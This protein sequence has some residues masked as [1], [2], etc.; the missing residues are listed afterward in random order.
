MG[1][2]KTAIREASPQKA[3]WL[4]E[5]FGVGP[6]NLM[7]K[8]MDLFIDEFAPIYDVYDLLGA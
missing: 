2:M 4:F 8:A 3:K 1:W 5:N 6:N 7:D